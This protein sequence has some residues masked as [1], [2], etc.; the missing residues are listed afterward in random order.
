MRPVKHNEVIKPTAEKLGISEALVSDVSGFYWS[1][2]KNHIR[3]LKY[4]NITISNFGS[5]IVKERSLKKLLIKYETTYDRLIK[6]ESKDA[7]NIKK[8][9]SYVDGMTNLQSIIE[10]ECRRRD[11]KR[12]EKSKYVIDKTIQE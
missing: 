8:V 11:E 2:V 6:E 12:K 1:A 5:F 10:S 7:V 3:S 4:S 9:K